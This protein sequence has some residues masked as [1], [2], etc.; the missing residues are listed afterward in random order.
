MCHS[1]GGSIPGSKAKIDAELLLA[2]RPQVAGHINGGPTSLTPEENA[3][4]V[5]QGRDI[6][7]QL[8]QAGNLRFRDRHRRPGARPRRPARGS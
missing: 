3:A 7:L 1:G 4:I 2:I 5:E 8:V 6:A